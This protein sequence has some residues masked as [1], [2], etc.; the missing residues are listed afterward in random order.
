[1][2]S[3]PRWATKEE[4][5]KHIGVHPRTITRWAAEGRLRAH[6]AGPRLIRFDLNEIDAALTPANGQAA[7]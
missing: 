4:A 7:L 1:M 3:L 5:A 2:T 6:R